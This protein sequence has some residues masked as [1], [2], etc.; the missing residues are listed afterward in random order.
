MKFFVF[1]LLIAL[2][3]CL[4]HVNSPVPGYL[5]TNTESAIAVTGAKRGTKHGKASSASILG[6]VALGQSSI[7]S[8]AERAGITHISHVDAESYSFL[9]IYASYTIHVYGE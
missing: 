2:T 7:D 1:A 4:A 9:G 3:G 6:L 8:A 5:F